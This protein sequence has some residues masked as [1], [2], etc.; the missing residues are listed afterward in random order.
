PGIRCQHPD[1]LH[2]LVGGAGRRP[3]DQIKEGY[4]AETL[5]NQQEQKLDQIVG[6]GGAKKPNTSLR[7]VIGL[8]CSG[9]MI[10]LTAYVLNLQHQ[11]YDRLSQTAQLF[12]SSSEYQASN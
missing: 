11:N 9:V 6:G 10:A 3:S 8:I 2:S 7:R 1:S 12:T 5:L 4:V